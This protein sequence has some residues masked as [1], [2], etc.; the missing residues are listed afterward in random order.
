MSGYLVQLMTYVGLN[1]ILALGLYL[2]ALSGQLSLG[3]AAFMAVGAY[4][5]AVL[6]T[7]F[8]FPL[9]VAISLAAVLS[10]IAG[11]IVAASSL[12]LR[13]IY[14]ALVTY[15]VGEVVVGVLETIDY[16]GGPRGYIG[17][18]LSTTPIL[19]WA[20]GIG[21]TAIIIV[22]L[23]SPGALAL[24]AIKGDDIAAQAVGVPVSRLKLVIFSAGAM[25]TGIGGALYAHYL[26]ILEPGNLGVNQSIRI[27]AFL[28]VGGENSVFGPL[29]GSL[30]LTFFQ[31][32]LGAFS[33]MFYGLMIMA[34]VI[35]FPEGV[36]SRKAQNKLFGWLGIG[37]LRARSRP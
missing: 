35:L 34:A 4:S 25:V 3:Q 10:F 24:L 2:A 26:G 27:L 7:E 21:L 28:V 18:P 30:I 23:R 32:I 8:Q 5:A 20:V 1:W 19:V 31:E 6:T 36:V 14:L 22:M 37:G 9:A 11:L 12:R 33:L 13:G 16:V 15:A 17:I 29:V